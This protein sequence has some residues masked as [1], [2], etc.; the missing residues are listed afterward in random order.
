MPDKMAGAAKLP[1]LAVALA[2]CASRVASRIG[3]ALS[4]VAASRFRYS[5]QAVLVKIESAGV[6][7]DLE[8]VCLR[9]LEK[10]MWK[11]RHHVQVYAQLYRIYNGLDYKSTLDERGRSSRLVEMLVRKTA[12]MSTANLLEEC[13]SADIALHIVELRATLPGL[14]QSMPVLLEVMEPT[15]DSIGQSRLS[16]IWQAAAAFRKGSPDSFSE[17]ALCKLLQASA[18]WHLY[19]EKDTLEPIVIA[20]VER[21]DKSPD[22][23]SVQDLSNVLQGAASVKLGKD[24]ME[25]LVTAVL[26]RL[27]EVLSRVNGQDSFNLLWAAGTVDSALALVEAVLPAA[28]SFIVESPSKCTLEDFSNI[29]G[30]CVKY[31][32]YDQGLFQVILQEVEQREPDLRPVDL[33]YGL[34]GVVWASRQVNQVPHKLLQMVSDL[35]TPTVVRDLDKRALF[36]LMWSYQTLEAADRSSYR[37]TLERLNE[38]ILD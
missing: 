21:M 38:G 26:S 6:V 7:Q 19:V 16:E 24:K 17:A 9:H 33:K 4:G 8:H 2:S 35:I 28:T 27:D 23:F 3:K 37:S 32:R 10:R 29:L 15:P 30:C 18:A 1:G 14:M 20:A 11:S 31:G 5:Y 13:D 12:S 22:K 25:P 34:A 36:Q